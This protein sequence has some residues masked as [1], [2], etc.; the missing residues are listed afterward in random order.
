[1]WRLHLHSPDGSC[2]PNNAHHHQVCVEGPK[3]KLD[4]TAVS[5]VSPACERLACTPL[6]AAILQRA[7]ACS[8]RA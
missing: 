3:E 6:A 4:T 1:L 8:S 2:A 7:M 5:Q